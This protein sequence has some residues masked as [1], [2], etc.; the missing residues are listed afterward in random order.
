MPFLQPGVK[1]DRRSVN[2]ERFDSMI[3][4]LWHEKVILSFVWKSEKIIRIDVS[5]WKLVETNVWRR[6]DSSSIKFCLENVQS[7]WLNTFASRTRARKSATLLRV[8]HLLEKSIWSHRN[9]RKDELVF[10]SLFPFELI[11]SWRKGNKFLSMILSDA[12]ENDNYHSS[13][14]S[15]SS[16]ERKNVEP[17]SARAQIDFKS[18]NLS[19]A[20]SRLKQPIRKHCFTKDVNLTRNEWPSISLGEE[21]NRLI[22]KRAYR[23]RERERCNTNTLIFSLP[24]SLSSLLRDFLHFF[25]LLIEDSGWQRT[26]TRIETSRDK[27]KEIRSAEKRS[28]KENGEKRAEFI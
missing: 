21:L 5:W 10:S 24:L 11:L 19:R 18:V 16:F 28:P 9:K 23:M 3:N 14:I 6:F 1:S 12:K 2:A 8:K 7:S 20:G 26:E 17:S 27:Q 22:D 13:F 15:H 25:A 4:W